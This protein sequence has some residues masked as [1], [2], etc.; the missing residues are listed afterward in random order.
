VSHQVLTPAQDSQVQYA[1]EMT[2]VDGTGTAA[3]AGMY[4]SRQII[5]KTG[6]TTNSHSGFFIGAIPQYSLVVGMFT[7][8][9][10][11]TSTES[12]VP[13]GGGGFGGSRPAEIWNTFALD[14]FDKLPVD[15]F[16]SPIFSGAK[17]NQIGTL[18]AKKKKKTK[19]TQC[20]AVTHGRHFQ[21][22][23]CVISSPSPTPTKTNQGQPTSSPTTSPTPTATTSATPTA[24]AT[25]TPTST[26]PTTG[27][28]GGVG[29]QAAKTVNGVQ[30]GLAV[31]GGVLAILPGSLLWTTVATRKRRRRRAGTGSG[32]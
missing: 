22:T 17:W 25:A 20:T 13:L 23:N 9:Q 30:A 8:L 27:P 3:A 10:S 5:A 1:M 28:G 24:T 16:Q 2:T 18:P 29:G 14:E 7:A 26:A 19:T 15:S 4:P 11:A 6:T 32:G 31:G 12:L 21:P